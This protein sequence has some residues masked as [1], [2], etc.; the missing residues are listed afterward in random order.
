MG[1]FLKFLVYALLFYLIFRVFR[2]IF[3]FKDPLEKHIKD[4]EQEYK[5]AESQRKEGD[6]HVDSTP[7]KEKKKYDEDDGEYIDYKEIK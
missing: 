7:K 2:W 1:V 4:R 3:F 5:R 6:I